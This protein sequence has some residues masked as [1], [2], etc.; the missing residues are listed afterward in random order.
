MKLSN[1]ITKLANKIEDKNLAQDQEDFI[2]EAR[3]RIEAKA[4]LAELDNDK[5]VLWDLMKSLSEPEDYQKLHDFTVDF[6]K[7]YSKYVDLLSISDIHDLLVREELFWKEFQ[8]KIV[9]DQSLKE[10]IQR[11][12]EI[13]ITD[14]EELKRKIGTLRDKARSLLEKG[15]LLAVFIIYNEIVRALAEVSK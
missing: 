6:K 10:Q 3:M 8:E 7:K 9:K 13:K 1:E 4:A 14:F 2:S 15:N 11:E 12:K 5:S